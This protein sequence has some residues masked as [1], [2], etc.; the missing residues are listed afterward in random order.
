MPITLELINLI[1][2]SLI[3]QAKHNKA[4]ANGRYPEVESSSMNPELGQVTHILSDK[5]G[6][7]TRNIMNFRQISILGHLF[8]TRFDEGLPSVPHVEFADKRLLNILSAQ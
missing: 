5:T 6:T 3:E 2:A 4:L 7:L 8:G 1:H